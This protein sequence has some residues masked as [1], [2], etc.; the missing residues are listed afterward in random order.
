MVCI[1]FYLTSFDTFCTIIFRGDCV[2]DDILLNDK[3]RNVER[4]KRDGGKCL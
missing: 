3:D 2:S 4:I 1:R